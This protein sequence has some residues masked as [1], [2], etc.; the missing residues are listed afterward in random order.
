VGVA[1]ADYN[2]RREGKFLITDVEVGSTHYKKYRI[3]RN[4]SLP[5]LQ[6]SSAHKRAKDI[7]TGGN[8]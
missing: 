8:G 2:T 7:E 4:S 6:C 1:P 3:F 5:P